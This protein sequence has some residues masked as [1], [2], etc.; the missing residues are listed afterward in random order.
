MATKKAKATK[1]APAKSKATVDSNS[2]AALAYLLGWVSGLLVYLLK[3][4]DKFVRFHAVQSI[5]VF[6]LLNL[7]IVVPVIGWIA[8][9]P[10]SLVWFILV[11]VLMVK[12]YQGKK[13]KLPIAG[14]L[15][16]QYS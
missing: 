5:I 2:I 1:K 7:F 13:Y 12:A 14:D 9:G 16:E 15:A 8:A 3:D 6:G 4:D 11:I 10:L